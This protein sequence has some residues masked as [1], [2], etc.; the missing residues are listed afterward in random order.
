MGKLNSAMLNRG[1]YN[2]KVPRP[3]KKKSP[4]RLSGRGSSILLNFYSC[5]GSG[6]IVFGFTGT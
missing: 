4:V 1:S 6:S 5:A 2:V 3:Q